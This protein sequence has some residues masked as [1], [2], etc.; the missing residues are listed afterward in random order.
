MRR[1]SQ[2]CLRF[3]PGT[4]RTVESERSFTI[5]HQGQPNNATPR[6]H[7]NLPSCLRLRQKS[8]QRLQQNIQSEATLRMRGQQRPM[9]RSSRDTMESPYSARLPSSLFR[10]KNRED[11]SS[12]RNGR[13]A[14]AV[15][16]AIFPAIGKP[17]RLVPSADCL[18]QSRFELRMSRPLRLVPSANRPLRLVPSA[19]FPLGAL[20][21]TQTSPQNAQSGATA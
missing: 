10:R 4:L 17:L 16:S 13:W 2:S 19:D 5:S 6:S 1:F 21:A 7:N 18:S 12:S 14:A 20:L 11:V 3:A 8:A 9:G 15:L